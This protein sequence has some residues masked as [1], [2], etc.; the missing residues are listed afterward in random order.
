MASEDGGETKL[1]P[2]CSAAPSVASSKLNINQ[3]LST[4]EAKLAEF[5]DK[6][7]FYTSVC[8]GERFIFIKRL[9]TKNN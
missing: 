2:T 7:K 1:S 9:E 6:A 5:F 4:R 8:L 3:T